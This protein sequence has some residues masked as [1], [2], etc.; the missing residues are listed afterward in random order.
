VNFLR[1]VD[2]FMDSERWQYDDTDQNFF[3]F[4]VGQIGRYYY[5]LPIIRLRVEHEIREYLR[6]NAE[7]RD[8]L[9]AGELR[10]LGENEVRALEAEMFLA[11]QIQL[12]V[13]SYYVFGKIV[14]N[15]A[16]NFIED[17]FGHTQDCSFKSHDK[18]IG[19]F[20]RFVAARG[21]SIPPGLLALAKKL[22]TVLVDYRDKQIEHFH[23]PRRGVALAHAPDEGVRL[24][25]TFL[26]PKDSDKGAISTPIGELQ[27]DIDAYVGAIW[28]LIQDN[29]SKSRFKLRTKI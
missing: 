27:N 11:R 2:D 17:Y 19:C 9:A 13:E 3:A 1:L 23:N 8:S 26:E 12:D 25:A 20:E 21:L 29:R 24:V 15:K 10:Q 6:L 7:R 28:K 18:L 16:A 14:L 4:A 5:F 22:K